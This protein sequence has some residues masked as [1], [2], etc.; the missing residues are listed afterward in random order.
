[1]A[2]CGMLWDFWMIWLIYIQSCGQIAIKVHC[3]ITEGPSIWLSFAI[4]F[5]ENCSLGEDWLW[6]L[7]HP[8]KM[9]Q[10]LNPYLLTWAIV[11]FWWFLYKGFICSS[12][13]ISPL[14]FICRCAIQNSTSNHWYIPSG[15]EG[16]VSYACWHDCVSAWLPF[17]TNIHT[18][19][20]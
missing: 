17:M 14:W 19:I 6:V 16:S 1:M 9:W 5:W 18:T 4:I 7:L 20:E 11:S 8:G 12:F 15:L 10:N 13:F 2:E 3:N